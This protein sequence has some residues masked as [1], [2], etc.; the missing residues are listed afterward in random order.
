MSF[1]FTRAF[2][3][4]ELQLELECTRILHGTRLIPFACPDPDP[5]NRVVFVRFHDQSMI[6]LRDDV[7][8]SVADRIL[9][10]PPGDIRTAVSRVRELTDLDVE[11]RGS[12]Y[13]ATK[14]FD[15]ALTS[16]VIQRPLKEGA[17]ARSFV[18][19]DG[20]TVLSGCSSSRENDS[21]AEAWVWTDEAARRQGYG[22]RC[23]AAW[24]NDAL[25]RGKVPFYSH[26]HD[27]LA[28][29]RLARS[30]GLTWVFDACGFD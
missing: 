25:R 17:S 21:A 4:F 22:R 11:W 27:N 12:T 1:D 30:L 26:A 18:I 20:D 10:S 14:P 9:T 7:D 23:V 8:E 16:G 19:L 15:G 24:A 2:A 29:R 13:V 6:F 3:L 28:S 5:P